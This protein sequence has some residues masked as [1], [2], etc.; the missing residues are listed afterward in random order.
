MT[1]SFVDSSFSGLLCGEDSN[2]ALLLDDNESPRTVSSSVATWRRQDSGFYDAGEG[3]DVPMSEMLLS[4]E[5]LGELLEKE[6]QYMPEYDYLNRLRRGDLDIGA[7]KDAIDW[8]RKV[9]VA[10]INLF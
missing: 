9:C 3:E 7:R 2:S 4:A 8:I 5:G 10:A 1:P 6:S